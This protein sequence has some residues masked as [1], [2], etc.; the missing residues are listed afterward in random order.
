[1]SYHFP[2]ELGELVK[3][4]ME[5]GVYGSE[6]EL[7]LDAL[8]TLENEQA[9]WAAVGELKDR[10]SIPVL[11]NGDVW[12]AWDALRMMRQT[13]CDGSGQQRDRQDR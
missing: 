1:M 7:L 3:R 10:L 4:Q 8:R 11:G 9:D 5:S 6:D 12:E 2:P 13:G